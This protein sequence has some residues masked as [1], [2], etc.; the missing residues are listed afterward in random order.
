MTDT[1]TLIVVRLDRRPIIKFVVFVKN[2]LSP[3]DGEL[4]EQEL[5]TLLADKY[6]NSPSQIEALIQQANERPP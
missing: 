5:R 4:S 6:K 3:N 2:T 1:Q